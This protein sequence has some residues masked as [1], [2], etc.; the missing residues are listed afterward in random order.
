MIALVD[1]M[2]EKYSVLPS[3]LISRGNTLD[4]EFHILAETHKDRERKKGRGDT[5]AL[6]ESYS[7]TEINERMKQWQS[8]QLATKPSK[9]T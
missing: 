4:I 6:A 3:D 7:Q 1:Q 8:S 5:E 2:A 9:K